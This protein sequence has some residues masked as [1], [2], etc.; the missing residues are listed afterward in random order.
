MQPLA[1]ALFKQPVAKLHHM[2][3]YNCRGRNGKTAGRLSEHA[4]GRAIDIRSIELADGTI[5]DVT[6]HWRNAGRKSEFLHDLARRACKHFSV[7]LTPNHDH[8]HRDH[9]HLDT[10]PYRL[11]GM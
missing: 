11:C 1:H 7:V 6:R 3:T 4:F 10:G 9:I 5:I 2:G 8:A